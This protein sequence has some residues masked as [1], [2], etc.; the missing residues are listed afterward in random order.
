M[1]LRAKPRREAGVVEGALAPQA[2]DRLVDLVLARGPRRPAPGA[3]SCSEWSRR[4]E[5]AK[6]RV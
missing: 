4:D 5:A 3:I 2:R 6:R 1:R